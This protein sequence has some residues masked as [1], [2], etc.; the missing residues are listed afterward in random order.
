MNYDEL[1]EQYE[2]H[3][4]FDMVAD[5]I[6]RRELKDLIEWC[7]LSKPNVEKMEH[8]LKGKCDFEKINTLNMVKEYLIIRRGL[9]D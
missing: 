8:D 6:R 4:D 7:E 5:E 9:I 1:Y 3:R 2:E